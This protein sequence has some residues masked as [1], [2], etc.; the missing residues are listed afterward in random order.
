MGNRGTAAVTDEEIQAAA[1]RL[2]NLAAWLWRISRELQRS[3][4]TFGI[5]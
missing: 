1:E 4:L 2:L 5:V 3:L